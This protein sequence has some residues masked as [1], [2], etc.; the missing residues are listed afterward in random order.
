[1]NLYIA[2]H[3][4]HIEGVSPEKSRQLIDTLY[5]HASNPKYTVAIEV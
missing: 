5:T 3:T 4:H 1:M 2:S